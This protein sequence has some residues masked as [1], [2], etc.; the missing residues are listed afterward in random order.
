MTS[1]GVGG[2]ANPA[3][4]CVGTTLR[5]HYFIGSISRFLPIVLAVWL[6]SATGS[7]VLASDDDPLQ[8]PTE[9]PSIG[10]AIAQDG[11]SGQGQWVQQL[12]I[13]VKPGGTL[14]D[15]SFVVYGDALHVA[16]IFDAA[17]RKN[18]ALV[19]PA[20]MPV[21]QQVDLTIDP[22][23]VYALMSLQ[24]TPD[25]LV[26]HFTNGVVR[27]QFAHPSG[28]LMQVIAFPERRGT[29]LFVYPTA[30]GPLKVRPGGK[31]VDVVYV[32]GV[33][34]GDVVRDIYGLTNYAT[35]T[36]LTGQTGWDPIHWPPTP[37]EIKRVVIGPA[38]S[39]AD[40]FT[41]ATAIPNPDPLGQAR[42][43][44]LRADRRKVG[45]VAVRNES[46]GRVYHVAVSDPNATAS[47][48]STLMYG[49]PA[50]RIDIARAAGFGVPADDRKAGAAYDPRLFGRAFD[51]S[52]DFLDESFVV[53]RTWTT[54]GI[55]QV[56]LANG[57]KVSTY[58]NA[59]YG[60][61]LVVEYPTGFRRIIY[62]PLKSFL[63]AAQGLALFHSSGNLN[64]SDDAATTLTRQYAAQVIWRWE[65]GVPRKNGD[66]ADSLRLVDDSQG[67]YLEALVAPPTP[68]SLFQ[69]ALDLLN[70]TNPLVMT[71]VVIGLCSLV[72]LVLDLGRRV[73]RRSPR[74]RW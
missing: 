39:Y 71:V 31:I 7:V 53:R 63:T 23:T 43:E 66:E 25:N 11:L 38:S 54:S 19:S 3:R 16:S 9:M 20:M 10:L 41:E 73:I 5:G 40:T 32:A 70:P 12:R 18:P 2:R 68:R 13:T 27:T 72:V 49:S 47:A 58:P 61:Q 74:A 50:H 6:L 51:L 67:T 52:V 35:A 62:R 33:S 64:L 24:S 26:Q 14:V 37:G 46:F 65:P 30:R 36:D 42:M 15:A 57:S 28:I 56:D 44:S 22:K 45:I 69:R 4:P 48:V 8:I 55:E 1:N 60:P 34:F 29:D 17:R 59:A 21:N